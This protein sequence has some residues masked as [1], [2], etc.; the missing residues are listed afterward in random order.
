MILFSFSL[1]TG[2]PLVIDIHSS[3]N[4]NNE[5]PLSPKNICKIP[6]SSRTSFVPHILQSSMILGAHYLL[7]PSA[8]LLSSAFL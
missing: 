4:E 8:V 1:F 6:I 5:C 2:T 3:R 7:Y